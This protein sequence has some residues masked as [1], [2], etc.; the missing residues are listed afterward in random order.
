MIHLLATF[1]AGLFAAGLVL[2]VYRLRGRKPARYMMP[3]AA[4]LAMLGYNL[5][6]DYSWASRT[7]ASLP[8]RIQVVETFGAS[9]PWKP[10]TYVVPEI[11]RFIAIDTSSVRT[12][13]KLPG[14]VLAEV[15]LVARRSPVAVTQQLFD[16]RG[17]RRTD[18]IP[19]GD[20]DD[21]GLPLDPDWV[22]VEEDDPLL[23]AV[24]PSASTG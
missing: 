11:D 1:S 7:I 24:C 2:L 16:C 13:E 17:A 19:S 21:Q 6:N 15:I 3:L 5:W 22:P 23:R 9:A 18:V 8:K 14:Y 12:N 4:G 10:W 20:F